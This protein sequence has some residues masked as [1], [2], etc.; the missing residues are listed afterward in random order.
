VKILRFAA[1]GVA[2]TLALTAC[3]SGTTSPAGGGDNASAGG[4]EAAT[5]KL[6]L[7]GNDTNDDLRAYLV[8]TFAA[9]NPGSKLVI[10]EQPWGDLDAKLTTALPDANNTPDVVELGNTQSPTYTNVGAFLDISDMYDELGGGDLLQSFVAAGE[11]DGKNFTLP[12]Y[13]GSRYMFLRTDVWAEA[14]LEMPKTLDEFNT[15]VAT[16]TEKNP[17][18]IENFSGFFLGG[19]DWQAG[20]SWIFANGGDLATKDGDQWVSTLSDPKSIEGL[21]Q[22]QGIYE[23][24]S[25]APD[26]AKDEN[27][28]LYINDTDE[29]KDDAGTVTAST[30]LAAGGVLATG[31]S[32]LSIGDL[33]TG[34]DGKPAREWNDAKFGVLVLPGN[35]GKPAP[36]FAGGS[37]IGI[38]AQSQHPE[39]AKSLMRIVF[40]EEYQNMLGGAGLGPANQKFVSS[41]GD[42]QFAKALIDSA[43]NS[44]LTPAAPGWATVESSRVLEEFFGKISQGGDVTALA[45]EYDAK[46]TPMLNGS[47]A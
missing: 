32:H 2:A 29:A 42:D 45:K 38:S 31:W 41:L 13:F 40:S 17:R 19:Q 4:T 12:Y 28:W 22:L 35:D 46:I 3:S 33:T 23:N 7:A 30:S 27:L 21:T 8:E 36:I 15:S 24:A 18:G 44:K 6:W 34:A 16:L 47:A 10:E 25:M 20:I 26:D 11:V 9:E 14:G 5:I 39:L 1:V 43:L 37:N